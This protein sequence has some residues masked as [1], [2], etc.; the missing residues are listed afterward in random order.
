[1]QERIRSYARSLGVDDIGFAA[2]DDY[3]SPRS[4]ALGGLLSGARSLVVL[5]YRELSTC[6][7]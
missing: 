4:P 2:A 7:S 3:R 6:D 5:A 1:M